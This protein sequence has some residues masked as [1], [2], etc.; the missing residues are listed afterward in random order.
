MNFGPFGF[1]L[2]FFGNGNDVKIIGSFLY[3]ISFSFPLLF[4]PV[5]EQV[6]SCS[7]F[8]VAFQMEGCPCASN[9]S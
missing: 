7:I 8:A 4:A 1:D 6:D 2:C 9:S 3:C 5:C